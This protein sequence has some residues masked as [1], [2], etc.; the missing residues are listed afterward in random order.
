MSFLKRTYGALKWHTLSLAAWCAHSFS[1]QPSL[2]R[3]N[4]HMLAPGAGKAGGL[5]VTFLGVSTL[6]FED[7]ET[8]ILTDGFFTRP[9]KLRTLFTKIEPDRDLIARYL[10]RAGIE[11]LAAVIVAH[12]H[13]D[14]AFDAPIVAQQTGARKLVGSASTANIARGYG[15]A[16][17]KLHVIED[18][19]LPPFGRF[20]VRLLPSVH[21]PLTLLSPFHI[22]HVPLAG[23][24][25][26]PLTLP[27]R[28]T[29]YKEGGSYSILIEH[30]GRTILVQ[31]SAGFIPHALDG[32]HADTVFLGIGTLGKLPEQ[33]RE[34]YWREVV[35]AVTPQRLIPIHWDNFSRSLAE[36]LVPMPRL[37]DDFDKSMEFLL[38]QGGA[39]GIEVKLL[40]AWIK[41]D[42]FA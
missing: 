10:K 14:H 33:Y 11:K 29:D 21:S 9:G 17:D 28:W 24:I 36:P 22:H 35:E 40:P 37:F 23:D 25:K 8:A 41:V 7:G 30:D 15:L 6:L 12:S 16:E 4:E 42:P 27:A 13:Y 31:A 34:D 32:R 3:Y 1:Q 18:G 20:R 39:R 38:R 5:R 19:E 2:A 26:E